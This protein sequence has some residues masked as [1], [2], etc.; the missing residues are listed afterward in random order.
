MIKWIKFLAGNAW[1][2]LK[3]DEFIVARSYC[4]GCHKLIVEPCERH[5]I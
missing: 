2:I 3:G 1:R 5:S 4:Y